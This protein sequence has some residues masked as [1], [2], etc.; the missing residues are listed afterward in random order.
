MTLD[1]ITARSPATG[2]DNG[3]MY[4]I[5]SDSNKS[6]FMNASGSLI[7]RGTPIRDR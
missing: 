6:Q 3:N 1:E 2:L 5:Q 7:G 4:Y